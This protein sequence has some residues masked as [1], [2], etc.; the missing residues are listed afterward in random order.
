MD[1]H[2]D[3]YVDLCVY[4]QRCGSQDA[5]LEAQGGSQDGVLEA[6]VAVLEAQVL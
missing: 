4:Q 5:V 2:R 6:Q 3:V 1:R